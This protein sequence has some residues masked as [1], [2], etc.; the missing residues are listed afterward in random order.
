M[1]R[2]SE[3]EDAL[4]S[5]PRRWVVT[6]AAGFIGSHLVERL[7]S[8]RQTVTAVDNFST[9][10]RWVADHLRAADGAE[11]LSFVEGDIQD[12]AVIA[13]ACAGAHLVLHQAALGS[14][15]RSIKDPFTSHLSNVDGFLR[16]VLAA[17]DTGVERI[18]FASSSSVYGDHPGLPKREDEIG[19]LMSPYA[20]TKRIDELYAD[21]L[22][23][24][25]G[26][27]LIGLRYFNVFGPRQDPDG[28]YAAVIPRWIHSMKT[29]V[30]CTIL[31]D[32]ETS[33]DFCFIENVIQANLLAATDP[34]S[35]GS[36][37]VVCNV[38]CGEQTT[39]RQ[40]HELIATELQRL[41]GIRVQEA[42][43]GPFREGDIR[44]SLAD[45]SRA[46]REFGYEPVV[47]VREG[48]RRTVA[49]FASQ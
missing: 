30:A 37:S 24:S 35:R 8:L 9:G 23:R 39:L 13:N 22:A 5:H 1:V 15:P 36:S 41:T 7:L 38:A 32:G 48:V 43:L 44:H 47:T 45:I 6:G 2:Y 21:V 29:G 17:R 12:P 46:R 42:T 31:G 27:S 40:L 20:A 11:N 49:W 10:R 28:P 18:V 3:L 26:L 19:R 14:V 33:R 16:V 25:Y 4:R 34:T